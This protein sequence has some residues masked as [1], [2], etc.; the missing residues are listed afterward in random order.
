VNYKEETRAKRKNAS[1]NLK[2][3]DGREAHLLCAPREERLLLLDH[4][5]LFSREELEVVDVTP[6]K[7]AFPVQRAVVH[8]RLQALALFDE[9]PFVRA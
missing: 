5:V 3:K 6:V 1:P 7:V 2:N 4:D 8:V 9:P